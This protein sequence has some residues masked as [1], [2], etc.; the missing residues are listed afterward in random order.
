[1]CVSSFE[2]LNIERY[3]VKIGSCISMALALMIRSC[4]EFVVHAIASFSY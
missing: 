3:N 4:L 1:M 2:V